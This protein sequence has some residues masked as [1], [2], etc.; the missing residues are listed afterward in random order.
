MKDYEHHIIWLEYFNKNLSKGK[1]RRVSKSRAVFDPSMDELV[2]AAR[3]AGYEPKDV[4]GDAHYPRRAYTR[5]GYIM[6]EKKG[7][8]SIALNRIADQLVQIRNRK[9]Q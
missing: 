3:L 1:G 8:K 4:N 9:K 6:V 5:S 2:E 7:S